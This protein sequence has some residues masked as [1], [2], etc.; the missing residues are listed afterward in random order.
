[1]SKELRRTFHGA[2]RIPAARPSRRWSAWSV[3][4]ALTVCITLAGGLQFY[5]AHEQHLRLHAGDTLAAVV[6]AKFQHIAHWRAERLADAMQV[7]GNAAFL[8]TAGAWLAADKRDAASTQRVLAQMQSCRQAGDYLDILLLD[9]DGRVHLS[10]SGKGENDRGG[11]DKHSP[12][13][14]KL[15]ES[16]P[17]LSDWYLSPDEGRFLTDALVPLPYEKNEER[18]IGVIVMV[19]DAGHF[20]RALF[21]ALPL[22]Q[23]KAEISLLGQRGNHV[24]S[25]DRHFLERDGRPTMRTPVTQISEPTVRIVQGE[26]GLLARQRDAGATLLSLGAPIPGSAWFVMVEMN[27]SSSR[28]ESRPFFLGA[29]WLGL[30]SAIAAAVA[31]AGWR[32]DRRHAS[33]ALCAERERSE[34]LRRFEYF[35]RY[36]NDA[37]LLADRDHRIVDANDRA[38][39]LY[40]YAREELTGMPLAGVVAG[41][42]EDAQRA[43]LDEVVARGS[44]VWESVHTR[45]DGVPVPV[46]LSVRSINVEGSDFIQAIVRD[47]SERKRIERA[48]ARQKNL[49]SL[50]AQTNQ[51]IVRHTGEQELFDSICRIAVTHGGFRF[52]WIGM[53]DGETGI[54]TPVAQYGDDADY[55]GRLKLSVG[56]PDQHRGPTRMAVTAG[57]HVISDDFLADPA[58]QPWHEVGRAAGVRASGAFPIRRF[59]KVVGA[60]NLYAS[61]AGFFSEDI[62]AVLDTMAMDVS[63]ALDILAGDAERERSEMRLR[64]SEERF[65][66]AANSAPVLIWMADTSRACIFFNDMWLNFTGRSLEYELGDGWLEGV[67]PG[68]RLRC[69]G[70]YSS[71]FE[72]RMPFE[73]EYRL[74]RRDGEYRTMLGKATPRFDAAGEFVGYIGSCIDISDR[75]KGDER[76]LLA[77]KVFE[78]VRESIMVTDANRVIVAVNPAFSDMTGYSPE[79]AVGRTPMFLQSGR[80]GKE[81][82][83]AMWRAVEQEGSWQGEFW[84][85]RKN[86]EL[87]AVLETIVAVRDETG[88]T[89]NYIGVAADISSLKEAEEHIHH[90][91]YYDPLSALPNRRYLM[92]RAEYALALA[93]RRKEELAVVFLD[94]DHFKD[95]NDSLGHQVGD[96]L[97]VRVA[98]QIKE[99]TRD[100]D[101]IARLGGDEFALLLPDMGRDGISQVADKILAALRKPFE[102]SGQA[103]A[104]TGSIG[105]SLYPHDGSDFE[106]LLRNADTAMYHAKQQGRNQFRFYDPGMNVDIRARLTVLSELRE[107]IPAGELRTFFQPEIDLANGQ[108]VGAEALVRW[109]H[110]ARGLLSPDQF[111]PIAESNDLIVAISDWVLEDTCRHLAQWQ[112]ADLPPI[113][114]GVNLSARHFRDPR[115]LERVES[116]LSRYG[117]AG[118]ALQLELTESTLLDADAQTMK[119]LQELIALGCSLSIDDFGTGYSSLS[120]LKNLPIATLKID[121]SFVRD[122]AFD[123]DDRTI[124]GTV[125]A[126]GHSLGLKVIAEGVES[127][128]QRRILLEQGCDFGQGYLFSRPLGSKEFTKWR[129]EH[130]MRLQTDR[131]YRS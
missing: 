4:I 104:V 103:F 5:Q 45:K 34:L 32:S 75:K 10:L 122:I 63:F 42:E 96:E 21:E 20:L 54:V 17:V 102:H 129:M 116:L 77:G 29:S 109:Q 3:I 49:Y 130:T 24:V 110:P 131:R 23:H 79:E 127:E 58:T 9:A 65:R 87:F 40:G 36:A 99:F 88:A 56:A 98:T 106:T 119:V 66:L 70:V 105:I 68:D 57:Q 51:I 101:T 73:I 82:Y 86:G 43:R 11:E 47:V 95:V 117:V 125:V 107:A 69:S 8:S 19:A 93:E 30:M 108:L 114:V 126:L 112:K 16:H 18:R 25:L 100:T 46:E 115:L 78:A 120:Y 124:A 38:L 52:A 26:R 7:A 39:E 90:L 89:V 81:Y 83:A 55:V 22:F 85:R 31:L 76:L 80:H 91:A 13:P 37:I 14:S 97:L 1:M 59:G 44:G 48:L 71:A 123:A 74:R 84:N 72:T 27:P 64:E 61:E 35:V 53:V 41:E 15:E 67:H 62:V 111:I 33:L 12:I 128:E 60:I 118:S 2:D 6:Q 121:R 28:G 50:L 113:I 94:V 92:E